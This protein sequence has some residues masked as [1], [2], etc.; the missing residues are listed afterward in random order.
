[1]CTGNWRSQGYCHALRPALGTQ[2]VYSPCQ[3]KRQASIDVVGISRRIIANI[4]QVVVGKRQQIIKVF[5]TWYCEGH[6]LLEDVPGVAKT[7]LRG[8]LLEPA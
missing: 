1:M 2:E 7:I 6:V 5:V 8:P 4:E 3:K